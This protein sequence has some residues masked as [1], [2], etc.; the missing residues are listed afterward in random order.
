LGK[1]KDAGVK[2]MKKG[3]HVMAKDP[4]YVESLHG[5]G[6]SKPQ[7][8]SNVPQKTSKSGWNKNRAKNIAKMIGGSV[9]LA[10]AGTSTLKV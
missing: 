6:G 1:K 7:S 3:Q 8:I 9:I 5:G 4:D 10:K 2:G